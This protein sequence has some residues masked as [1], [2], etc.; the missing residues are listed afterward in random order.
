MC[1]C[2]FV[3]VLVCVLE[4]VVCLCVYLPV[5]CVRH[6]HQDVCTTCDGCHHRTNNPKRIDA[7]KETTKEKFA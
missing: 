7:K 5:L 2:V 3:C 4:C 1:G 6:H